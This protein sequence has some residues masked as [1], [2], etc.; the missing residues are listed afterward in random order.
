[1]EV[2]KRGESI[3]EERGLQRPVPRPE[4][5]RRRRPSASLGRP[6]ER[7]RSYCFELTTFPHRHSRV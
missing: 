2:A 4:P 1:M 7:E 5:F 6:I 3:G